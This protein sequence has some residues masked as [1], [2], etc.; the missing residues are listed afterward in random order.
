MI[1]INNLE[2]LPR[3][4]KRSVLFAVDVGLIALSLAAAFALRY[5]MIVPGEPIRANW[6]LFPAMLAIGA[7]TIWAMRLNHIKIHTVENHTLMRLA[8]SAAFLTVCAMAVS[9]L[10]NLSAPRSVPVIFGAMFFVTSVLSHFGTRYLF[11]RVSDRQARRVPVAIYGAGN[12]GEQLA[13][14]LGQNGE[15]RPV[16]FIDD[17]RQLH[18]LMVSGLKVHPVSALRRLIKKHGLKRVLIAMPSAS[19]YRRQE[20][21]D[22]LSTQP[23]EVMELP[24][25]SDQVGNRSLELGLQAKRF[26]DLYGAPSPNA[27]NPEVLAACRGKTVFIAGA[28][29]RVGSELAQQLIRFEPAKIIL[30]ERSETALLTVMQRLNTLVHRS[31][32][33]TV[34]KGKTGSIGT[35]GRVK[36]LLGQTQ[37]DILINAAHYG[38]PQLSEDNLFDVVATNVLGPVNL[39]NA[40]IDHG[41]SQLVQLSSEHVTTPRHLVDHTQRLAEK[42]LLGQAAAQEGSGTQV[43]LL[44]FGPTAGPVGDIFPLLEQQILT[45]NTVTLPDAEMTRFFVTT[46]RAADLILGALPFGKELHTRPAHLSKG[47]PHRIMDFVTKVIDMTGKGVRSESNPFGV[48]VRFSGLRPGEELH[49]SCPCSERCIPLG[50]NPNLLMAQD[51]CPTAVE[52]GLLMQSFTTAMDHYDEDALRHLLR[53]VADDAKAAGEVLQTA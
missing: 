30:L 14:A 43:S 50:A 7:A 5:G 34:I 8:I 38:D 40:A 51:G 23:I 13:A 10:L 21:L 17:N 26:K 15:N 20:I 29:G 52:H 48:E 3:R 47:T 6:V 32:S 35:L 19:S 39:L 37:V 11:D 53:P 16:C 12:T 46:S 9:F 33:A 1:I 42:L 27:R 31:G 24:N 49:E 2:N 25:L 41:V 4:A 45:H 28:G 44:R 22:A 18:G 36:Q